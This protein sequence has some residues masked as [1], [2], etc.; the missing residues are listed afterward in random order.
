MLRIPYLTSLNSSQSAHT[1]GLGEIKSYF[2]FF[3]K[4]QHISNQKKV[5]GFIFFLNAEKSLLNDHTLCPEIHKPKV[6]TVMGSTAQQFPRP[7]EKRQALTQH[8]HPPQV[9]V[10][11]CCRRRI[12]A[13]RPFRVLA[14]SLW[15]NKR[16]FWAL[17]S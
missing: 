17:C 13:C 15:R 6:Y 7:C 16:F 1:L 12:S 5:T 3:F 11:C 8:Q 2:F 14:C 4:Q 9:P 10:Q